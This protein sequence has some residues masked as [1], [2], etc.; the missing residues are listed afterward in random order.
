MNDP[1]NDQTNDPNGPNDE[2]PDPD[3]SEQAAQTEA[4]AIRATRDRRP[5]REVLTQ[6]RYDELA[7]MIRGKKVVRFNGRT[8]RTL[9]QL[10]F[11]ADVEERLAAEAAGPSATAD[12][13]DDKP[14]KGVGRRRSAKGAKTAGRGTD[15]DD[16]Q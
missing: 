4:A 13:E 9:D 8:A 5:R 1:N 6:E 12:E 15:G 11:I 16:A 10:D 14:A 3:A 7:A 2:T